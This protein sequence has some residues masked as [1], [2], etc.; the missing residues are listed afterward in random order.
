M[1]LVALDGS[2]LAEAALMPAASLVM[3]LAAPARGTIQL[4]RVVQLPVQASKPSEQGQYRHPETRDLQVKEQAILE[5]KTYLGNVAEQLR[6][7]L[8]KDVNLTLTWSVAAGKDVAGAIIRAAGAGE[9]AEG[10]RVYGGCD[11]IVLATHCRGGLERWVSGSVTEHILGAT[12]LLM[13]IV[14]P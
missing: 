9:D 10:T 8:L 1:A 6:R 3:P 12:R 5:A 4:T 14:K 13:L 2:A 7:G 11:L